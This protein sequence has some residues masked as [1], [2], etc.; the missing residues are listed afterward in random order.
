[1]IK[2]I[3]LFAFISALLSPALMAGTII[4]IQSKNERSTVFT[5]SQQARM[6]I[7]G[8]EYIIVNYENNS[9]K[10]VSPQQQQVILL[11]ANGPATGNKT[12]QVR[13]AVNNLGTG[14]VVA[15]YDTQ[16]FAYSA[17]GKSCGVIYGSK[18]AYQ[19][20]GVKELL[21]AMKTLMQRQSEVLGGFASMIDD[22]TLA[23]MNVSDHVSIIGVPMLTERN[24]RIETEI[25]SIKTDVAL[26]ENIFVVPASYKTAS[27]LDQMMSAAQA[28]GRV[29]Q[30]L[31]QNPQMQHRMPQSG[32]LPPEVLEQMRRA[33]QQMQQYPR[34]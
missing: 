14:R 17:N 20:K 30:Q 26:P 21:S 8:S 31:Q 12:P 34:R 10:V 4:E 15:G 33:Q 5:D 1:M 23:D 11:D 29:Q 25:K 16:K 32:Q 3:C 2:P 22:C 28:M 18:S 6:D 13:T 27:L 24:G 9:I 19:A 7:G